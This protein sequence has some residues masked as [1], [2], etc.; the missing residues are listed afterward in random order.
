MVYLVIVLV[1]FV[2]V[3]LAFAR[4]LGGLNHEDDRGHRRNASGD[5]ADTLVMTVTAPCGCLVRDDEWCRVCG[6]CGA[7]STVW[8]G[9]CR[10]RDQRPAA[11]SS[12][13][14]P[15]AGSDSK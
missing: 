1:A 15:H 7:P 5:A 4:I 6:G 8:Q 9:C 14:A 11:D 10:C 12:R 13:R 3:P 2:G